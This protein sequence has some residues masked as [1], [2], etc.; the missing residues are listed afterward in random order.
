MKGR[1]W[2]PSMN[3]RYAIKILNVP[4]DNDSR[5]QTQAWWCEIK[6]ILNDNPS[7]DIKVVCR[8]R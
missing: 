4:N 6:L 8:I 2:S 1:M 5:D 3:Y 7:A